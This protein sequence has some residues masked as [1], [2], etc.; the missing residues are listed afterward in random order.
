M[1]KKLYYAI[2]GDPNE[3]VLKK[4][5]PIVEDVNQLEQEF[6]RKSNGEL[7]A[8]TRQFQE[9]IQQATAELREELTAAE[10]E[11]LDVLGTEEQKF[12]RVEVDRIKK[13]LR[14]AE[15]A[16][17]W[18]ILPE[19]FAAVRE[20]SKRTTGLR[21]YDVQML[22]GMVLHSGSIAEMKTGEG[23]TLVATLPLYLNALTR[24]G[25]HLVTPND[26]L[27]KVGL[28]LMG[29]IYHLLGLTAAV[30][31]NSAGNPD[32]GS[33]LFDPEYPN[34]D[35]RFQY[36]KPISRREAYAADITYGTNNEFGFDYLR[37]NMVQDVKRT[38]QRE[39]HYAIVDEVDNILIDEARTP[40]IISGE[41]RES[42]N[43][44]VQFADLAKR[45][46]PETH[47]VVNEKE[48]VA[49]LTEEGIAYVE[50]V[51]GVDNL[52]APEH[53][54]MLPYL[55]NALRAVALYKRDKDYIVRNHEVVIVDEFTGRLMEGRRY[56]EGLHQA[57]EAKEGVKVQK[58]SMTLATITFQNFFRM[59]NKLAGMTGT[60]KTEEEEFQR[61]YNLDVV[62]IPTYKPI[63]R[64]DMDDLV[65]RT[66]DAKFKAVITDIKESYEQGR[67]VLVGTVAIETSEH[68][69]NLLRRN[70]IPH[71]VLNAKNHEREATII[72]Q[73]GRPGAVTIATN[74]AG[75]GVDILLGGNP[76]GTAR[77]Q[78]RREEYDLA[79]IRQADW[80]KAV[81]MLKH[82]QDPT[83]QFSERWAQ[84][85]TEKWHETERD[86]ELVK[87]KGGLHVVGTERHEA[88]RIDNQLRGRSGRLGD[89]GS[90]RFY[91]SLEDELMRKF[92]GDRIS[93]VMSRLGVE[94]DVP[95]EAGLVNRA[96]ENAQTKVEGYNFDIRKHVLRYDEVVNEQRN[97]I[98]DQRR[99]ILTEP[100]L[101]LTVESMIEDE[102]STIVTHFT[103]GDYDDEWQLDE[104]AQALKALLYQ[105]PDEF[106]PGRW[107]AMK[108]AEIE[109]DAIALAKE[110]YVAKES[111]IGEEI[112]RQAERQ[113]MLWAVDSRWVRHLTDLDR[114]REG[115][116]LQALAQVDPVVAYK[117]EAFQ[118]YSELIDAIRSD[119]VKAVFNIQLQP[120]AEQAT[121]M[122]VTPIARNIRTNRD[123][124]DGRSQTVRKTGPE[125]GRND[126]CW[127]GSGKKYKT[128]HMK[129]DQQQGHTA[130][131]VPAK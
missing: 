72:A 5:R 43:Y 23:K 128:C 45:L 32:L 60:A 88:R 31:Q 111:E 96:I 80:N 73:A 94:E 95:I 16:I 20:A 118:M 130:Q 26:Y 107:Q 85:L 108:R 51:L 110:A 14:R 131:R 81:D 124:G 90:S 113:I 83:T 105:L 99:R 64:D 104:L 38:V 100:S 67:P 127:C 40:L 1:I 49:T 19:A 24:R 6:E 17:L 62:Q 78:L 112:M 39:L 126:P 37:D 25:A 13:E 61:I 74:M 29:P 22:G 47:Y 125:L 77:E 34:A 7:R 87:A 30:I 102:V 54:D 98:Y 79:T 12:A 120:R 18:E 2:T 97:R 36:L 52:Y 41:A 123:G 129:S 82:G 53:F 44:Y 33:F 50:R 59:Y 75:R 63:I 4:Y 8:M 106:D 15:E 65:Y 121:A 116:G 10:Q 55:D 89:P 91:L 93:G 76:E 21:H 122:P 58:E 117:R 86:K 48:M 28:Q 119:T 70:G 35:D 71:E 56:S 103:A 9:R 101:R 92:G 69:S 115:I 57:I 68:V 42:S 27:S 66:Q 114:L 11:Y 3:K 109:A 46:T 84:V